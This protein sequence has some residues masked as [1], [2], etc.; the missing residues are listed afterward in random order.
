MRC[1]TVS[2][3]GCEQTCHKSAIPLW[4]S[5][6]P[7]WAAR[8]CS[9]EQTRRCSALQLDCSKHLKLPVWRAWRCCSGQRWDF[10]AVSALTSHLR[11]RTRARRAHY[12]A[13]R[14]SSTSD[15]VWAKLICC[16]VSRVVRD[17]RSR[18]RSPAVDCCRDSAFSISWDV[19]MHFHWSPISR[20]CPICVCCSKRNR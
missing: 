15:S 18:Y 1:P 9:C 3:L 11:R 4:C 7:D 6:V 20:C 2:G 12:M 10:D 16:T 5:L 8:G 19:R 17:E 14:D 13:H